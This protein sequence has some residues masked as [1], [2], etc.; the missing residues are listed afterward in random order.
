MG[1]ALFDGGLLWR[2][3][4]LSVQLLCGVGGRTWQDGMV[5]ARLETR[6]KE[7]MECAGT[8]VCLAKPEWKCSPTMDAAAAYG[9]KYWGGGQIP[10]ASRNTQR[11]S[12]AF[13]SECVVKANLPMAEM[14]N[15]WC[16]IRSSSSAVYE[17]GAA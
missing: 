3:L 1:I 15:L 14:T 17:N 7:S 12:V 8:T 6:I 10:P 4:V 2:A 11:H 9:T 5:P 16:E 13:R